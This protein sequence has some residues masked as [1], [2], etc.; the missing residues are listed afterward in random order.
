[1]MNSVLEMMDWESTSDRHGYHACERGQKPHQVWI[2]QRWIL[3]LNDGF[4]I[5][6]DECF[7]LKMNFALKNSGIN[8]F[9]C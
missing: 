6:N 4:C 5:E 8:T 3:Y 9:L 1:M 2:K 7:I